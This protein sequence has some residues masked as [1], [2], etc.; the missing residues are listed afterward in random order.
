MTKAIIFLD[1]DGVL[2]RV[3]DRRWGQLLTLPQP[4]QEL[5]LVTEYNI[6]AMLNRVLYYSPHIK[7]VVSS[8]WRKI[9]NDKDHF[10]SLTGIDAEFIHEDWTTCHMGD[11]GDQVIEWL[12]RHKEVEQHVCLDDTK[13]NFDEYKDRINLVE[14]NA[15]YG[16][17]FEDINKAFKLFG[18]RVNRDYTTSSLGGPIKYQ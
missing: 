16:L 7:A 15:L 10:S 11:R 8:T 14:I 17:T 18:L 12:Y 5:P 13:Y 4:H 3:D 6:C 1:V 9:A 2:N